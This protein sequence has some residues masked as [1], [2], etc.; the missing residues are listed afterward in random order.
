MVAPTRVPNPKATLTDN[1]T[2][3]EELVPSSNR[4][5]G[6]SRIHTEWGHKRD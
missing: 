6:A 4:F 2:D 1:G 3:F 5:F